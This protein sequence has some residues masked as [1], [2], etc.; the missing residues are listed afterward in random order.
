M[1]E[2]ADNPHVE[3]AEEVLRQRDAMRQVLLTTI[4]KCDDERCTR[5]A[6]WAS[7]YHGDRRCTDHKS[8][9]STTPFT[10][11]DQVEQMARHVLDG[12]ECLHDFNEVDNCTLCLKHKL[13]TLEPT[14]RIVP[15]DN[16]EGDIEVWNDGHAHAY[17]PTSTLRMRESTIARMRTALGMIGEW[18]MLNP[19]NPSQLADAVW[20]RGVVDAGLGLPGPAPE[21]IR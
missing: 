3:S 12:D 20:L 18:D 7:E 2:S 10:G 6:V 9:H 13:Y 4:T 1:N 11:E 5:W 21:E 19:P 16:G 14:P 17:S 8:K 15:V